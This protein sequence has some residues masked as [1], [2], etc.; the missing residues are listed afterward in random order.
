MS[1]LVIICFIVVS[2]VMWFFMYTTWRLDKDVGNLCGQLGEAQDRMRAQHEALLWIRD[3]CETDTNLCKCGRPT[4][5][6]AVYS[7]AKRALEGERR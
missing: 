4:G 1:T 6:M 5:V 3:A 7:H 2:G